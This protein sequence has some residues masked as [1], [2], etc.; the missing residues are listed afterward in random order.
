MHVPAKNIG[1]IKSAEKVQIAPIPLS[2][3]YI[4]CFFKISPQRHFFK[5]LVLFYVVII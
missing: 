1:D 4:P 5:F 2:N 3:V